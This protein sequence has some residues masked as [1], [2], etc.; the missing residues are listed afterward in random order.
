M[1]G[2][3]LDLLHVIA[4]ENPDNS[5]GTLPESLACYAKELDTRGGSTPDGI[6]I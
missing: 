3:D 1:P 5:D 4:A 6:Q 2:R